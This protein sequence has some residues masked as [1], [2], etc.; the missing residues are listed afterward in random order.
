M[1]NHAKARDA[2]EPEIVRALRRVGASVITLHTPL[3]LIVGYRGENYLLEIKMPLGPKGGENGATLTPAQIT[4]FER[5]QGQ[6]CVVR[7][8]LEALAAIGAIASDFQDDIAI[9]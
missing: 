6:A 4:F 5:W 9:Q 1:A 2:N 3:D 8:G 7:S